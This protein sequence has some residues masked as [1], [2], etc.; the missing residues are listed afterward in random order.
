VDDDRCIR[1]I[2]EIIT[3]GKAKVLEENPALMLLCVH[4]KFILTL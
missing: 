1:H 3:G 4:K 2:V